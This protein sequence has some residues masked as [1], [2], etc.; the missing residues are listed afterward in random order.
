MYENNGPSNL[1]V[2]GNIGLCTATRQIL[3]TVNI[4]VYWRHE[5]LHY[6]KQMKGQFNL[7]FELGFKKMVSA[8]LQQL[9]KITDCH[10]QV[11]YYSTGW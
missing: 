8:N 5:L 10:C 6:L 3:L 7:S 9:L 11:Q 2:M 4:D 1:Q